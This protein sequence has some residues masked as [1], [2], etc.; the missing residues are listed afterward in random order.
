MF[1]ALTLAFAILA[2]V[3]AEALGSRSGLLG[4]LTPVHASLAAAAVTAF[5]WSA[6]TLGLNR[7]AAERR[8]RLAL[9]AA[10]VDR[11]SGFGRLAGDLA[12]QGSVAFGT[13]A[14][15]GTSFEPSRLWLALGCAFA[16]LGFGAL[17][18][19]AARRG[20]PRIAAFFAAHTRVVRVRP[21]ASGRIAPPPLLPQRRRAYALFIPNRPPPRPSRFRR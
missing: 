6:L 9:L 12:I 21:L 14:L 1:P 2:H 7:P 11:R 5:G 8:R 17:V 20:A 19:H 15:E 10:A 13:L 18:L 3:L 4:L 16:A